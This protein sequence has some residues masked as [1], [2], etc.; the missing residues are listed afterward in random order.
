MRNIFESYNIGININPAPKDIWS[1]LT[2]KY[3]VYAWGH[4]LGGSMA[5]NKFGTATDTFHFTAFKL[6][7]T[8]DDISF[9][10]FED[11]AIRCGNDLWV[12]GGRW[13][14]R[15]YYG[16]GDDIP[17][18]G[19]D[20]PVKV[21]SGTDIKSFNFMS[22]AHNIILDG[23]TLYSTGNNSFGAL[24][25]G[26][27]STRVN[28]WQIQDT[29][30]LDATITTHGIAYLKE[31]GLYKCGKWYIGDTTYLNNT[32]VSSNLPITSLYGRDY[33]LFGLTED[34]DVI[35]IWGQNDDYM[36]SSSSVSTTYN[37]TLYNIKDNSGHNLKSW[38]QLYLPSTS[39]MG[40]AFMSINDNMIIRGDFEYSFGV[41]YDD[42]FSQY[43]NC[44]FIGS[45]NPT[46]VSYIVNN[47]VIVASESLGLGRKFILEPEQIN[48]K[49]IVKA[50]VDF[51]TQGSFTEDKAAY[52]FILVDE[53]K[54][55][56]AS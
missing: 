27:D 48:N 42:Y 38:P 53:S 11:L 47:H 22:Q 21:F 23:T 18:V 24:N 9:G 55:Y 32:L 15:L 46:I 3:S 8:C 35:Y 10:H 45:Q 50:I 12:L 36:L 17:E 13:P 4:E 2:G 16:F 41:T 25:T 6:P 7:F 14:Q 5:S 29:N 37:G 28:I 40:L 49:T 31:D 34:P 19:V 43:L 33:H 52:A 30:V 44:D 1:E 51:Y 56:V 20:I 26:D 39:S 54:D